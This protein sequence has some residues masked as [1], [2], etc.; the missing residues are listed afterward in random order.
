MRRGLHEE[1]R[2]MMDGKKR[3]DF[4]AWRWVNLI[5]WAERFDVGFA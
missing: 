5:R 3:F 1:W 2:Q 4:R